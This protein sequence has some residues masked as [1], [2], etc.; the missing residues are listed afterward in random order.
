MKHEL[1]FYFVSTPYTSQRCSKCGHISDEARD[2]DTNIYTCVSPS[3]GHREHGDLIASESIVTYGLALQDA[4]FPM[5][6][7]EQKDGS[8]YANSM[9]S[10][11]R[12]YFGHPK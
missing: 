3:C 2:R 1:P 4:G 7:Q 9:K 8:P 11:L 10:F 6:A 12:D 5:V